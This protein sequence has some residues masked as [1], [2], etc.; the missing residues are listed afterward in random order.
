[1]SSSSK[2]GGKKS[3]KGRNV[4]E[5]ISKTLS[6]LLRHEAGTS[7]IPVTNEGWVRWED[8]LRFSRLRWYE[9]N[10]VWLAL[11]NNEKE[12]FT[13]E[14]DEEGYYWIAAWSGHTIPD[15]VGPSRIVPPS[16][17][18]KMLVHGT[19]RKHVPQIE[20]QGLKRLRRD[21]HLQDPMSHARRWRKG[22]EVKVHVDTEVAMEVG[23]CQ[24]RVTGN[25]VWLCDRDI[26]K[27]AVIYIAEW[28]DLVAA[29]GKAK[30]VVGDVGT[31]TSSVGVW[32][33]DGTEWNFGPV[34]EEPKLV[35][36]RV[37]EVAKDLGTAMA[38]Y[39]EVPSISVNTHTWEVVLEEEQ[40]GARYSPGHS[41]DESCDWSGD[42]E[43][44]PVVEALPASSVKGEAEVKEELTTMP[45]NVTIM[46]RFLE[47]QRA[48]EEMKVEPERAAKATVGEKAQESEMEVSTGEAATPVDVDKPDKTAIEDEEPPMKRPKW[49][50]FG[51]AQ[52]HI[53]QAVDA[54]NWSSLQQCIREQTATSH[55]KSHLVK[56]LEQLAE[57]R[58]ESREGALKALEE[59]RKTATQVSTLEQ[60]YQQGLSV[61]AARLERY[62]PVGPRSTQPLITTNRLEADI[63][64]GVGVWKARR[65]HRAR[66]RAASYEQRIWSRT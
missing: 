10:D 5:D 12:R 51:S 3:K 50:R 44:P 6:R 17:V 48:E 61:E 46:Q 26:P 9:P 59:H 37:V 53:L 36:Q 42:E 45:G 63:A 27:E 31:G 25:L 57:Q 47:Q 13:A 29:E 49:L 39:P 33:P 1:M 16:E 21:L 64:A 19:Y 40:S 56:R 55:E 32:E 28:D 18:P 60:E 41:E 4:E 38:D 22:L 43:E 8:A 54:A 14:V 24:F 62:N 11:V 30:P 2:V 7:Q 58:Q 15:C 35:T 23:G 66:E 52:T 65:D 20:V 34:G